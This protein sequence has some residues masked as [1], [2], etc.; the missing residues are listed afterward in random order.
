M[1]RRRPQRVFV[2]FM[3]GV[4]AH[5]NDGTESVRKAAALILK[6]TRWGK[7]CYAC[8]LN[9]KELEWLNSQYL[10]RMIPRR[11]IREAIKAEIERL[12]EKKQSQKCN[13]R[14]RIDDR[15]DET[16]LQVELILS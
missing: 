15:N 8:Q 13:A 5:Y 12:Y 4:K 1:G 3:R 9:E 14:F 2:P 6:R 11:L 10:G 16:V 7:R